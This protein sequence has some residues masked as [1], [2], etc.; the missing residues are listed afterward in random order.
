VRA[1]MTN[2]TDRFAQRLGV[3]EHRSRE[4]IRAMGMEWDEFRSQSRFAVAFGRRPS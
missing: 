2:L 1:G 3:P 4:L